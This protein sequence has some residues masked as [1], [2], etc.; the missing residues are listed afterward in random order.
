[1][2]P[3]ALIQSYVAEVVRHLPRRQRKDVAYELHSLLT[4]ELEGRPESVLEVLAAFGRPAD[5]ADRYRPAGFTVLRASEAPRFMWIALGGVVVQWVLSLIATY[6]APS[7]VDWLS[8]LGAWWLSWGLGAF[9]WP[10]LLISLTLIAAAISSRREPAEWT[11][12]EAAVLDRDRVKRPV[13]VLYIALG[14]VG[15]A[16]LVALT[17]LPSWLPQPVID[18]LALDPQFLAWRAPWILLPWAASLAIGIAL[19]VEGR[20]N[21]VTRRILVVSDALFVVFLIWWVVA[22]PIFVNPAADNLTKVCLVL[23]A[24]VSVLDLVLNVRRLRTRVVSPVVIAP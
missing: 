9:W 2:N 20:W 13:I 10:G 14:L 1:M 16:T 7:D 3:D 24:A 22:G 19:L 23:L 21:V 5:V 18:A 12:R 6:S 15:A 8:R 17:N 4:E 11:P